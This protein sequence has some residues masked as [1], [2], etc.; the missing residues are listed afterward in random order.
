VAYDKQLLKP[1]P[2]EGIT[3][4][5]VE[6]A[7]QTKTSASGAFVFRNLPAGVY[8][9]E[10]MYNGKETT[11]WIMLPPEPS[12]VHDIELNVGTK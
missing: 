5:L 10:V 2:L 6:A 4:R 9:I 7:S 12:N 1:V 3:V 8:T 11:R